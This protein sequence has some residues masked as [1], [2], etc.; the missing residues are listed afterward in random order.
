MSRVIEVEKEGTTASNVGAI[1]WM[2]VIL[3]NTFQLY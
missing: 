2:Y 3:G 1:A